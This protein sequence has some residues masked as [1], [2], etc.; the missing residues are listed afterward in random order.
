MSEKRS[1]KTDNKTGCVVMSIALE[2]KRSIVCLAGPRT[3]GDNQESMIARA[4]RKADISFRQARSLFYGECTDPKF[5]VVERVRSAVERASAHQ[6]KAAHD[7]YR[8]L[9]SRISRLETALGISD[10]DFHCE[11]RHALREQTRGPDRPVDR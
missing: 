5:S 9:V 3:M 1:T 2:M 7:E 11:A 8:E 6:E 4:A 10:P